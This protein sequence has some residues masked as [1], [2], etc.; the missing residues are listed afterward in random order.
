MV[1]ITDDDLPPLR[2]F[3]T[4]NVLP[5]SGVVLVRRRA[6]RA[7]HAA[8]QR[9]GGVPRGFVPLTSATQIRVGTIVNADRG[10]VRIQTAANRTG[11]RTQTAK[12]RSGTFR[13]RQR[14]SARPITE[15]VLSGGDFRACKRRGGRVRRLRGDGRGAWRIRAATARPRA[16]H[17]GLVRRGH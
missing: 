13:I 10:V 3:R 1:T 4:A 15:M 9:R 8:H 17:R 11:T 16:G 12:F 14:R 5:V 7:S 6:V 2:A